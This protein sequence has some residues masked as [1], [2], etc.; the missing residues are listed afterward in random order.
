MAVQTLSPRGVVG[1][2]AGGV[3]TTSLTAGRR[4][5]GIIQGDAIPQ[6]FIPKM[7]DLYQAGQFPFYRLVKFYDFADINTAIADA[8]RGDTIKPVLRI[9]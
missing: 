1:L 9:S 4:T 5:V 7:I 2:L 6:H 8:K 3:V